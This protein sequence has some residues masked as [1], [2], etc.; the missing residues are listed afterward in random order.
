MR[1][2]SGEV[3]KYSDFENF[4]WFY[5]NCTFVQVKHLNGEEE[6]GSKNEGNIREGLGVPLIKKS[7]LHVPSFEMVLNASE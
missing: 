5:R 7:I 4:F 6:M 3:H 1:K 2:Q